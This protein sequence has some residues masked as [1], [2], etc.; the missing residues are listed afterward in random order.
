MNFLEIYKE[1]A[2]WLFDDPD[3]G[4]LREPFVIETSIV[5]DA[6]LKKHLDFYKISETPD[7]AILFFSDNLS[8]GP[9]VFCRLYDGKD[10][11]TEG[12][13]YI[14]DSYSS[15]SDPTSIWLCPALLKY[16]PIPPDQLFMTIR[17]YPRQTHSCLKLALPS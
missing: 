8:G 16:Y 17:T 6:L 4:L 5:L 3:K 1:G 10:P 12:T 13:T 14:L 7:R 15:V 9:H 11:A 2:L